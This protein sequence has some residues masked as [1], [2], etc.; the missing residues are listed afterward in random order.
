MDDTS[1]NIVAKS[2][3]LNPLFLNTNISIG[4]GIAIYNIY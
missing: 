4:T 1:F 2:T 3:S